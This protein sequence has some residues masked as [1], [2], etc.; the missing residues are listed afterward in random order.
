MNPISEPILGIWDGHDA[1][2]VLLA[3]GCLIAALNEERLTRR[4]LEVGFPIHA[5][6][7]CLEMAAIPPHEIRLVAGCTTDPAKTI[8][9]LWP[10]SQERYYRLRR[11]MEPPGLLDPVTQRAKYHITEWSGNPVTRWLSTRAL[12]DRLARAGLIHADLRLFDHHLCHAASAACTSGMPEALVITLDGLGDGRS[13]TLH[14]WRSGQL[15]PIAGVAARDS[16]GI[17]FEQVT[18]LLHLRELEDEGKVMALADYAPP[19]PEADNP[20]INLITVDGLTMR[21]RW[22]ASRLYRELQKIHWR[23]AQENFAAMAQQALEHWVLSWI[24]HAVRITGVGQLAL[25]GGVFANVRLNGAIRLLPGVQECFVFPHMGDGGLALGAACLAGALSPVALDSLALG[26]EYSESAIAAAL[27]ASGLPCRPCNQP[28]VT[29]ARLLAQGAVVGWYQG[30]MEYG[31]RALG[32]RSVLARPDLPGV[33]DRLNIRLKKRSWYQPF[34]PAMLESEAA[35]LLV[36][37]HGAPNRFMTALYQMRPEYHEPM[38]GVLGRAGRCRPQMVADN[39]TTPFAELLRAMQQETGYG[40]LLN[41]SFNPHGAPLV[42]TPHE[43]LSAFCSMGLDHLVI[44][45]WIVDRPLSDQ[46]VNI[47]ASACQRS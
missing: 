47:T 20:L 31:P 12:H 23:S 43:A 16:V 44:G 11:R 22:H 3:D 30:R 28:A 45:N 17:V 24:S 27:H 35:R 2:A 25:A 42:N 7:T 1:G 37:H 14:H 46:H 39:A 36:D 26:P 40:V 6:R 9:R 34:C 4:K 8:S 19:V 32:Q 21:A 18:R 38:A 33:R 29:T 41:T 13:G 10:A 5:I 15:T